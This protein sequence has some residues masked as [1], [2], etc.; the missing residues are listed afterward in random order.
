MLLF[1]FMFLN[2]DPNFS[3]PP[4][5]KSTKFK[6]GMLNLWLFTWWK[7]GKIGLIK[8]VEEKVARFFFKKPAFEKKNQ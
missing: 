3:T 7:K 1:P 2:L 8:S 6:L 4:M 5:W